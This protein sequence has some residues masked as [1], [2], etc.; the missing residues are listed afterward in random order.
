MSHRISSIQFKQEECKGDP[1]L[2][3]IH[4]YIHRRIGYNV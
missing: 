2:S 4:S 1:F 3:G